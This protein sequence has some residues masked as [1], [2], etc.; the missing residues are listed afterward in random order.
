MSLIKLY[1]PVRRYSFLITSLIILGFVIYK[2][3]LTQD[4]QLHGYL[5]VLGI[6]VGLF[7]IWFWLHPGTM[8]NI[9]VEQVLKNIGNGRPTFLNVY[10]NY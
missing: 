5:I 7:T 2:F 4:P 10:S 1:K 9:T 6:A 3:L 8:Q